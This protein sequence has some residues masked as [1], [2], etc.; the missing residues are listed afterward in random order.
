MS[1]ALTMKKPTMKIV[2]PAIEAVE[3]LLEY[4]LPQS[5]KPLSA[6]VLTREIAE[7]LVREWYTLR[8]IADTTTNKD[9]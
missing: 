1:D 8:T 7:Q 4:R 5:R 9:T 6:I 3:D 2:R